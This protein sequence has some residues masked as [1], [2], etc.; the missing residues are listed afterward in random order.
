M[1]YYAD[2]QLVAKLDKR[3]QNPDTPAGLTELAWYLRQRDSQ[4]AL[5]LAV[6]ATALLVDQPGSS[7]LARLRL[8]RAEIAALNGEF[9]DAAELVSRAREGFDASGD[10]E[11]VGDSY[12]VEALLGHLQGDN[13]TTLTKSESAHRAFKL[14][15][16]PLRAC[17]AAAWAAIASVQ[18]KPAATEGWLQASAAGADDT[19]ALEVLRGLVGAL[20]QFNGGEQAEAAARFGHLASPAETAGLIY[21]RIRIGIAVAAASANHGDRDNAVAWAEQTLA[22]AR[23]SGWPLPTVDALSLL[24]NLYREAGQIERSIELLN[25]ALALVTIAPTSRGSALVHAYLGH[26]ELSRGRAERALSLAEAAEAIAGAINAYPVNADAQTLAARALCR[27]GRFDQAL[28]AAESA[29][30]LS[31]QHAL[32]VWQIEALSAMADIHAERAGGSTEQ[33]IACLERAL[34]L[35]AQT[36]AG[37]AEHI[38]ILHMLSRRQ[39]QAG[40][41]DRA[42]Q[43]ERQARDVLVGSETQRVH[44]RLVTLELRHRT[45]LE[46]MATAHQQAL[47]TLVAE[48]AREF[49]AS[50]QVLENLGRIGREIT[51]NLDIASVLHTL[52]AHLGKLV[53]ANFVG[54]SVLESNGRLIIRRG[55]EDGRPR[56]ERRVSIDD[57][58]SKA[59]QCVRERREILVDLKP[60]QRVTA[61]LPGTRETL[62]SWFGPLIVSEELVGVLSIQS[63]VERAYGEREQLIFR[64]LSAYVAVA[65]ANARAYTR[66]GE[67]HARLTE[68]E[69]EM[70]RLATTDALTNI[71]NRRQFMSAL[72]QEVRRS[73]RNGEP[74]ALIM[75]DTDYFKRVNDTLG[76]AAG[77]LVLTR[78][79]RLLEH[80]KREVDTVGRLGGEEF[81]VLL[82]E[83]TLEQAAEVAERLRAVIAAEPV[84]WESTEVPVTM[85]FGCA[86]MMLTTP[87]PSE[88][89]TIE[90]LFQAADQALYEAKHAGRNCAAWTLDGAL[91][92]C[93]ARSG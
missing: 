34:A 49:E 41:L 35:A 21:L 82:P 85:S 7:L 58:N 15:D 10:V 13:A 79:A 12:M 42:L 61:H 3:S 65:V 48:R 53:E 24:G 20:R 64:T 55:V 81:A 93:P 23:R 40:N 78:I 74:L 73:R 60:G 68:V 88:T 43:I 84:R 30:A 38:R 72:G 28:A 66:L 71:P 57:P 76:H 8:V 16:D 47:A 17:I 4:R 87:L 52:V 27:L 62:S 1:D 25:E 6:R 46:A 14:A 63:T 69:A 5:T 44:D 33:T 77:D 80:G 59:A 36:S 70:R 51:A 22:I 67:Q 86:A 32:P 2:D 56:P 37:H 26:A 9:T 89:A 92:V 11:G 39:E 91:H 29:L 19:M 50:R 18:I 54:I 31:E 83:T 45:E 75:G 90:A